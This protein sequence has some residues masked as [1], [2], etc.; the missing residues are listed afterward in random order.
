ML[1]VMSLVTFVLFF[2]SPVDPAR[3]A[4]GKN[5]S[6]AQQGADAQGARLRPAR[7][8][9]SGPTSSRAWSTGA[10]TPTTRSCGKQ[11]PELV[12]H[13]PAPCLG[14]SD[15]NQTTVNDLVKEGFPVSL[16]LALVAL[17]MW[18]AG[19]VLFGVLAAVIKGT[20]IDRGI[21][22]L[23][24]VFFAFPTFFIGAV[25]AQVPRDQ[26]AAGRLSRRTRP[27]PRAAWPRG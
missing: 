5:C 20:F 2:A 21:V 4:C 27:S 12:T 26:V 11:A 25:P 10:T 16:S 3:F 15:V 9:C 6:P 8:S 14:Y 19:G 24:L 1:V 23:T 7:R 13:C 18:L 17:V 22:G